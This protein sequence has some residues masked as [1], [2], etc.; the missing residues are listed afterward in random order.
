[1]N[2]KDPKVVQALDHLNI[3]S[4]ELHEAQIETSFE[5]TE[6]DQQAIA[7]GRKDVAEGRIHT[8]DEFRQFFSKYEA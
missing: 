5:L 3:L 7:E 4:L 2:S 6:A 1:M 8:L